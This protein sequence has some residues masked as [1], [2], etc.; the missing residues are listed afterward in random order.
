M[1]HYNVDYAGLEPYDARMKAI[2]DVRDYV[3]E[4]RF[5]I[6]ATNFRQLSGISYDEFALMLSF[7]GIQGFPVKVLYNEWI[8]G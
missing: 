5:E 8:G 7:A 3:G 4:E 2:A 6:L 1:T